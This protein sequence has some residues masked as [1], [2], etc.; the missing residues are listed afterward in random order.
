MKK[1]VSFNGNR[2][3]PL[4]FKKKEL[5]AGRGAGT[6]R[7]CGKIA[8][9]TCAGGR[10]SN[11]VADNM[12]PHGSVI[13]VGLCNPDMQRLENTKLVGFVYLLSALAICSFCKSVLQ[14]LLKML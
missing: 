9:Q 2:G 5:V 11:W 8:G 7:Q 14:M 12:A 1:L 10:R 13:S 3:R 6:C 4:K